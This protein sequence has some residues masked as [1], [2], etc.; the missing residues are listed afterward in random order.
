MTRVTPMPVMTRALPGNRLWYFDFGT[1]TPGQVVHVQ[2]A[3]SSWYFTRT[4]GSRV[5]QGVVEGVFVQTSSKRFGQ[6]TRHPA[7]C[8]VSRDF[9]VGQ[10]LSINGRVATGSIEEIFLDGQQLT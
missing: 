8:S 3:S 5:K 4:A 1:I 10:Q 2:T 7:N 6:I 9:E